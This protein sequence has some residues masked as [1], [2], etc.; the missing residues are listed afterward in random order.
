[1]RCCESMSDTNS[2]ASF[3][4]QL[5]RLHGLTDKTVSNRG[6]SFVSAFCLAVQQALLVKSSVSTTY[7]PETDGQT[8][9]TNQ[10]METYL[11]HFVSRFQENWADWLPMAEFCFNN[12]NSLSTNLSPFFA[13]QGFHPR[14]NSFT[15][16]SEIPRADTF[17]SLL[18]A[19]QVQLI[20]ALRH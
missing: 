18:E 12:S 5:F 20:D 7:H 6:P 11:R 3:I 15:T 1:M 19:T 14:A 2:T 9:R 16:P 10:T 4:Q 8:E 17:V 13:C